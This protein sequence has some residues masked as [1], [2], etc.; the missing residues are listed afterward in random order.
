MEVVL[1]G[2]LSVFNES[3]IGECGVE[4]HWRLVV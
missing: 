4:R 2:I 1:L 3:Q